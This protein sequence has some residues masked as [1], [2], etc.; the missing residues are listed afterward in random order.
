MC[1]VDIETGAI[2][3]LGN[4]SSGGNFPWTFAF[5][6]DTEELLLVV[7]QHAKNVGLELMSS[8]EGNGGIRV[9]SR[10]VTTGLLLATDV[11]AEVPQNVSVCVVSRM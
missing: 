10:D 6:G 2:E 8:G 4:V 11:A 5:A 3:L 9:F 1:S 7:N